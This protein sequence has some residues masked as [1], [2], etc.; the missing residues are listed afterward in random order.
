MMFLEKLV[1]TQLVKN[2]L[3]LWNLKAVCHVHK[4][5]LKENVGH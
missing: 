1:V 3:L 2:P 5:S 4:T